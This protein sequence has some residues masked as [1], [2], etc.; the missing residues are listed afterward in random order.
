MQ[1]VH[2]QQQQ[3]A[4]VLRRGEI[5]GDAAVI[6][7]SQVNQAHSFPKIASKPNCRAARRLIHEEYVHGK[8]YAFRPKAEG[9]I[10]TLHD[11]EVG[12][13][14]ARCGDQCVFGGV[15]TLPYGRPC[16]EPSDVQAGRTS[17]NRANY[18]AADKNAVVE[19]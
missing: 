14:G 7:R 10:K 18:S 1:Q 6:A 17:G 15:L 13:A 3:S 9:P 4:V 11:N 12:V 2:P 19:E 8:S 16:Q 5:R